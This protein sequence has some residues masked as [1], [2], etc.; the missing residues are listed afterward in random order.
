[1]PWCAALLGLAAWVSG[2]PEW[3][4]SPEPQLISQTGPA[5][6]NSAAVFAVP[7][8]MTV[9][10]VE[11]RYSPTG[12]LICPHGSGTAQVTFGSDVLTTAAHMRHVDFD[13]RTVMSMHRCVFY[14]KVNGATQRYGIKKVAGAGLSCAARREA[15]EGDDWLVLKL[16]RPVDPAVTPYPIPKRLVAKHIYRPAVVMVAKS[17]DWPAAGVT[18]LR[19]RPR[20]Y[21]DCRIHAWPTAREQVLQTDCDSSP[22]ASGGS[23]LSA[24]PAPVLLGIDSGQIGPAYSRR[25]NQAPLR[26]D[27]GAYQAGCWSSLFIPVTGRFARAIRRAARE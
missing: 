16:D 14:L 7:H 26:R 10:E 11:A 4:P 22:G 20:H 15:A 17:G 1:M 2:A 8:R 18:P 19:R 25:C 23:L 21:G 3:S 5:D 6:R 9:S 24:G 27:R 13:C 12:D